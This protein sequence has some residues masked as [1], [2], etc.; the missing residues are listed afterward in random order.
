MCGG[1]VLVP[2]RKDIAHTAG[3]A[4]YLGTNKGVAN[5]DENSQETRRARCGAC[6]AGRILAGARGHISVLR[7][8]ETQKEMPPGSDTTALTADDLATIYP[9]DASAKGSGYMPLVIR[10]LIG[11]DDGT[12]L[13]YFTLE[14]TR[15][16]KKPALKKHFCAI[17]EKIASR[18]TDDVTK[19]AL[20][21]WAVCCNANLT[22]A[23]ESARTLYTQELA[24]RA[25]KT[26]PAKDPVEPA[27]VPAV[28]TPPS[29]PPQQQP[30]PPQ[31]KIE[32]LQLPPSKQRAPTPPPP[33]IHVVDATPPPATIC[34]DDNDDPP[35]SPFRQILL[36]KRPAVETA[37]IPVRPAAR[38][39]VS[40]IEIPEEDY[41]APE[42]EHYSLPNSGV[43]RRLFGTGSVNELEALLMMAP[44]VRRREPV[45]ATTDDEEPVSAF[46]GETEED[47][48]SSGYK[49][50]CFTNS[51]E[52]NNREIY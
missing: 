42:N 28:A 4:S 36:G 51:F 49:R 20:E 43:S 2:I 18:V 14:S 21:D 50:P 38:S 30:L 5:I 47:A 12:L 29:P 25:S 26:Q 1:Q 46:Y 19:K 6:D 17:F 34:V 7:L 24:L 35:L 39:Q 3:K 8:G 37:P 9:A 23:L 32:T 10:S 13:R 16:A 52:G 41:A 48:F 40:D 44:P 11:D 31:Q 22:A 33:V 15:T 27:S 45:H